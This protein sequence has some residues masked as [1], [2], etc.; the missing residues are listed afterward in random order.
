MLKNKIQISRFQ[1]CS[2]S[3][4]CCIY[5]FSLRV[6]P[7]LFICSCWAQNPTGVWLLTVP[8]SARNSFYHPC[9]HAAATD[10]D[11]MVGY[12]LFLSAVRSR[13]AYITKHILLNKYK[14]H[15]HCSILISIPEESSLP[16]LLDFGWKGFVEHFPADATDQTDPFV[17]M[18]VMMS[19]FLFNIMV[20]SSNWHIGILC[21][22][23]KR[24]CSRDQEML[25]TSAARL[26]DLCLRKE[27]EQLWVQVH[28]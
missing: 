27:P 9:S 16:W 21:H 10:T 17:V 4:R 5:S 23:L 22:F 8:S 25:Q 6:L 28:W 19:V 15:K 3:S 2:L 26:S 12:L 20:R 14:K 13:L 24:Y 1:L 11:T 18:F 7:Q